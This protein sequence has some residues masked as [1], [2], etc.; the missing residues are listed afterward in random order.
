MKIKWF[1]LNPDAIIPTKAP[2]AAGFDI[3]T[4]DTDIEMQPH[5]QRLFRTGLAV[6][7]EEGYWLMVFDRGSTGSKGLHV[8][9]GVIDNDYR[10]EIFICLKNDNPYPIHINNHEP[11]GPHTHVEQRKMGAEPNEDGI[12][13]AVMYIKQVEILD[14]VVYPSTKAIAQIIPVKQPTVESM[15]IDS[16]EWN[17]LKDTQRGAGKLGSSGK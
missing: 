10:G 15:E 5:T 13:P 4:L 11:A 2:E 1:K 6:V 8:H 16:D 3:Y 7:P 12:T 14:Y 9:C 17:K